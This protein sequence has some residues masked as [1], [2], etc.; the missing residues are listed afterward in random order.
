M[1][2]PPGPPEGPHN[3]SW[4]SRRASKSLL[5]LQ[6]GLLTTPDPSQFSRRVSLPLLALRM[7]PP[8][9][10]RC[11]GKASQPHPALTMGLPTHPDLQDG[12][13]T[14]PGP[15][16]GP[17]TPPAPSR[18]NGWASSHLPARWDGITS[19][20]GSP[21]GPPITSD[22]SRPLRRTSQP[23]L[24]YLN[25]TAGLLAPSEPLPAF[26]EDL[27]TLPGPHGGPLNRFWPSGWAS[28]PLLALCNSLPPSWKAS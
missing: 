19:C 15:H 16:G 14:L 8:E 22:P 7:G 23:L 25:L 5:A 17:P 2:G 21:D 24:F 26:L 13:P 20:P 12:L 28:Y 6:E 11:F 9:P 3:P 18:P 27:Q 4:M 10:S 1:G